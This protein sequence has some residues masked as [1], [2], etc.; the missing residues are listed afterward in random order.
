[1][2][3]LV[4]DDSLKT[5]EREHLAIAM[6][7]RKRAN[8]P[9]LQNTMISTELLE[10]AQLHERI[11]HMAITGREESQRKRRIQEALERVTS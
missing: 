4:L 5:I 7:S 3:T 8:L 9:T 6:E 2:K 10:L 11:A 1:M